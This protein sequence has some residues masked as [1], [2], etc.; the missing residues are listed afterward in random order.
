MGPVSF[1]RI[2]G[3]FASAISISFFFLD[4][5]SLKAASALAAWSLSSDGVLHLRTSKG[6]QLKAYFQPP[7]ADKGIRVWIDFP[8]ELVRP[9]KLAGSGLVKEIRLGK[10][11]KGLTRLVV[12]F[13]ESAYLDFSKLKLIGTSPDKWK[14]DF[15]GLSKKDLRTIGE[16]QLD[17]NTSRNWPRDAR[18]N[19]Q[20]SNL[21]I[22]SLPNVQRGRY[23]V[24]I[25]PGHGGPDPGAVGIG[26]LRETDVVLAIS[27]QVAEL[28]KAKGVRVTLTRSSEIDLDLPPRV[29][30]A[31][32]LRASAF[33][34]IHAN[35]S[36]SR[37]FDVNGIETF[38]YS[39]ARGNSLASNIQRQVLRVS[40]GSPDRGVRRGRFFVI[41][42]TNM[43]AA[44]VETGFLTGQIDAPRLAKSSHRKNLAIAISKGILLYLKGAR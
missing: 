1:R 7:V 35:A 37:R 4:A 3:F 33:V 22:S 24:V 34:S 39:G 29:A 21:D 9:R 8:G 30:I 36:R 26:R 40:P 2:A 41:R 42:R 44:L 13:D 19:Y 18:R 16:G 11:S 6:A 5:T 12:E 28:L 15:E 32:R 23:S 31:N 43:P 25:D 27:L 20:Y 10:P 38:Y 14:L 17:K